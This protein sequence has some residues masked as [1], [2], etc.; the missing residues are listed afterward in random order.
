MMTLGLSLLEGILCQLLLPR[1]DLY[2]WSL[3]VPFLHQIIILS[4]V[5]MMVGG[6]YL[7]ISA[8]MTAGRNFNH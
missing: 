5:A 3:P 4:G 8:E 1:W 7:R 2:N 6:H